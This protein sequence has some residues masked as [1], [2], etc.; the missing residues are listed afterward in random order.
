VQELGGVLP[1]FQTPFGDDGEVDHAILEKEF[2]RV[3]EGTGGLYLIDSFRRGV[4]GT[5]PAADLI[6]A[7]SALWRALGHGDYARAYRLA[8]PLA[9]MIAL[10]TSLDSFIAARSISWSAR[11]CSRSAPCAGRS[12]RC[13]TPRAARRSTG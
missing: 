11:A 13:S 4:V 8:G 10:Q 7:L 9:Q 5:M 6:W 12:A 1:V 3:F 2:A